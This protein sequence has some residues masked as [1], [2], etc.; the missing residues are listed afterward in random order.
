MS[1][2]LELVDWLRQFLPKNSIVRLGLGDDAAVVEA[3]SGSVIVTTDMVTD[4]VDF[5]LD[6]IDSKSVGHKALGVNLSDLAAMAARPL[7]AFVSLVLPQD[8]SKSQSAFELA[9]DLYRGMMPLA[10]EHN[11]ALAGGDTNSWAGPLAISITVLGEQTPRGPLTRSGAEV[12]D[13]LLVTGSLG[14]SILGRH[15]HVQPRVADALLLR[16][17]FDLHAGIDI[18][19]G[20]ALDASRLAAAS[21]CGVALDLVNLPISVDA[22]KAS[23]ASGRSPEEHALGDG[24]DFELLLAVPAGVAEEILELQP[25]SVPLTCIGEFVS[26]PGLW[27]RTASGERDVLPP[28][29]YLHEGTG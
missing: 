7:A 3:A 11:V 14:G 19:D 4:G 13:R 8:G 29:G 20:L 6:Q 22:F 2:E 1:L 9:C 28:Y 12:T 24:E 18:S 26:E 16:E 15:L 17:R 23:E 25:C 10:E 27:R 21:G 5:L